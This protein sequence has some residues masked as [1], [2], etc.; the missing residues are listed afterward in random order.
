MKFCPHCGGDLSAFL[1]ARPA[2]PA[3]A[4]Y[5]QV[6]TWRGLI[7][8]SRRGEPVDPTGLAISLAAQLSVMAVPPDG[9][10][11]IVHLVMDRSVVPEGGALY[12]STLSDGRIGP[13]NLGYFEARGY[14]VDDGRVR[15]VENTPIG[16]AY[17]VLEYWG[18]IKQHRRWHLA[19]PIKI[20]PSRNGDPFFMDENMI[21]F[22]ATWKDTEK[23]TEAFQYL[24]GMFCEGVRGDR[25]IARPLAGEITLQNRA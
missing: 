6:K 24:I 8:Q 9:L 20:N 5:D 16:P 18:G 17:D 12:M 19:E 15:T 21:A 14:L 13:T 22:G 1:S 4:K 23:A 3:T 25:C 10:R 7:E 2:A 11:T